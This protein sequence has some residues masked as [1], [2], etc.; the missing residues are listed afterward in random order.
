[1]YENSVG[2]AVL[3]VFRLFCDF[4]SDGLSTWFG[5]NDLYQCNKLKVGLAAKLHSGCPS[6]A[7]TWPF[8]ELMYVIF[9][10]IAIVTDGHMSKAAAAVAL[11]KW[12]LSFPQI[13]VKNPWC[14]ISFC[15]AK[16]V[17][18]GMHTNLGFLTGIS[19]SLTQL[20]IYGLVYH[21]VDASIWNFLMGRVA[22]I[23]E[24]LVY[25]CFCTS[26]TSIWK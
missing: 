18:T 1:M 10:S 9:Q 22:L 26:S 21:F 4:C 24:S 11:L 17:Y 8:P 3:T 5:L 19:K 14:F 7:F 20:L 16:Y 2:R 25:H 15:L 23:K 12:N 13:G 6:S